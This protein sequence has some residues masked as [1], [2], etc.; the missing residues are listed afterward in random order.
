[1]ILIASASAH[2]VARVLPSL[3]HEPSF[4]VARHARFT[5]VACVG[6]PFV[7]VHGVVSGPSA[8]TKNSSISLSPVK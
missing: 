6:S 1:M 8:E 4:L 3:S 7:V 2:I 5:L